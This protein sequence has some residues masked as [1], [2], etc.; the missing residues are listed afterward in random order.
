MISIILDSLNAMTPILAASVG[1]IVAE[2]SGVVN[3]GIE[4]IMLIAAFVA[5]YVSAVTGNPFLAFLAGTAIGALLGLVHGVISTYLRGDQIVAGIGIN[6]LAYGATTIG[7]VAVWGSYGTSP[8]V[9]KI[10]MIVVGTSFISPAIFVAIAIA[11]LVWLLLTRT[12]LG[13]RIRACGEDPR[14]AEAMGINIYTVRILSTVFGGATAGFAGAFLSVG[15]LGTFTRGITGG[16]GFIALANVAFSNWNPL[17]AIVGAFVFGFFNRIALW[18]ASLPH[19]VVYSYIVKV[20]PYVG[21]LA[22]LAL[23]ARRARLAIPRAL[24][25][26]YIKE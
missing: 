4:G 9:P 8:A 12:L 23:V 2:R 1:E 24:G 5:A 20:V 6:T 22:V 17:L 16:L 15:W 18:L 7:M 21:T 10:S 14:A 3:I 26:P 13:L 11:L 25:K 19:L